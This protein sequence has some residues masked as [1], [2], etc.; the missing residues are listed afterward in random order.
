MTMGERITAL[1]KGR[2][3][4][5]E[6]LAERLQVTRQSVSKWELDQSIP[7]MS[8]AMALCDI[9]DVSLDYLIRGAENLTAAPAPEERALQGAT[10]STDT[11]SAVQDE[12]PIRQ[13]PACKPLSFKGFALLFGAVILLALELCLHVLPLRYLLNT[14]EVA[15]VFFLL[16]PVIIPI[17]ALYLVIKRW[18]Y[19]NRRE[20]LR[21]LW[22]VT[23]VILVIMNLLLAGGYMAFG[24][25]FAGDDVWFWH[26]NWETLWYQSLVAEMMV[27]AVLIPLMVHFHKKKW[28]CLVAYFLSW[29]EFL[30]A[31]VCNDALPSLLTPG[32]GKY[33]VLVSIAVRF[34]M[35]LLVVVS[36]VIIYIRL[37]KEEND[38]PLSQP[39]IHCPPV[40]LA[41]ICALGIP[42]FAGG[43]YYGLNLAGLPTAYLPLAL[44]PIPA[45]LVLLTRGKKPESFRTAWRTVG[46]VTG[47]SLPLLF[48]AHWLTC[49]LTQYL[50]S[51]G[52]MWNVQWHWERFL[53]ISLI[54]ALVGGILTLPAMVAFRKHPLL[55]GMVYA[56]GIVAVAV[57]TMFL[58]VVLY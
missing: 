7:D 46:L 27:L 6:Q 24:K 56:L 40:V 3:M 58:P 52:V 13:E 50:L 48:V 14:T 20:A 36:Q 32:T 45:L 41:L 5:Q 33:W 31:S 26:I 54:S 16:Y 15:I 23:A 9:F 53:A 4:T 51:F 38:A 28:I 35:V 21:H 2:G 55:C 10:P 42:S 12:Q 30:I 11:S 19:S 18:C 29:G 57:A 49:Y 39:P 22:K 17:P 44:F 37:P 8:F 47:I 1:R 34:A 25:H 43:L